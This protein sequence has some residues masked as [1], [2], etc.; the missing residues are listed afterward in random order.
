MTL[1]PVRSAACHVLGLLCWTHEH[2][3]GCRAC[4]RRSNLGLHSKLSHGEPAL[5]E[6]TPCIPVCAEHIPTPTDPGRVCN[7]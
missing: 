6:R 3:P 2:G 5:P 1:P 7:T 4:K